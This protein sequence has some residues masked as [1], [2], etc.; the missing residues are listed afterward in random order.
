M[1]ATLAALNI[2]PVKACRRVALEAARLGATGLAGDR[3]WMITRPDGRFVSQRTHPKLARI[4]PRVVGAGLELGF[5]GLAPLVVRGEPAG[6]PCEVAV[7]KDRMRAV[8]AGGIAAEWLT[9]ALGEPLRLVRVSR[10]TRR[11]A[12]RAWVGE[13]DVPVSFSDGFPLLICSSASLEALNARLP[14]PVPMER[15]RPNLVLDGLE[16]FAED[17]IR[18]VRIGAVVVHLV[19]PCMRCTVPSVDQDTGERST[20]PTPA[21]KQFRYDRELRGVTF[22][23]NAFAVGAPGAALNVGAPLEVAA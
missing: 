20:D 5:A 17:R 3:E 12:D 23:V 8:D 7:W 13:R 6:E 2:Y 21:L 4:V 10:E 15:F 1:T 14:L 9:R 22:G 16:P 19:K 18:V 11:L